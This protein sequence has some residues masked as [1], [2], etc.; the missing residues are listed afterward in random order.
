MEINKSGKPPDKAGKPEEPQLAGPM[1]AS[2]A[3]YRGLFENCVD[4][5]F[6]TY[7]A[8]GSVLASN[9]AACKLTG[10]SEQELLSMQ[11]EQLI[12]MTE[13]RLAAALTSAQSGEGRSDLT[14]IRKNGERFEARISSKLFTDE[15]GRE[16]A[17][18]IVQDMTERKAE[19]TALRQ[20]AARFRLL[21]ENAPLGIIQVDP[22]GT[23]TTAN[24][25]F[26]EIS[27]Y[28]PEEAVG[29][30]PR[31]A[32]LPEAGDRFEKFI[33]DF[34]AGKVDVF[35][36][37]ERL[38][39]KDGTTIW[40][41]QHAKLVRDELGRPHSGVVIF[42]DITRRKQAESSL[43]QSEEKFRATFEHMPIGISQCT[44]DGRFMDA[45]PK[46]LE[47]LG[48]T[49]DELRRLTINDVTHPAD[50]EETRV[51][52]R[53]MATG[54]ATP[55]SMETRYVRKDRSI[56]WVHVTAALTSLSGETNYLVTT[57]E[58]ISAR[59][60][61]E[62]EQKQSEA[63]LRQSEEKFR[64]TF[65]HVPLGI[66]ECTL[67][68]RFMDA[69]PKLLE[70]LGYTKDELRQLTINDV[71]HPADADQT[72]AHL[73]NLAAG[74]ENLYVMEKRYIR[75]DRSIVWV[76][77][78]AALT[79][80]AGKPKY[81]VTTIEDISA[82]KKT[83]ADLKQVME[84]SYYQAN[85]DM[86]T[87]L[88]NRSAFNDRLQEALAY[89]NRDEHMVAL[90]LI[91]LD[92]FKSINDTLGH[93][94]GDLLL[95]EVAKRIKSQIRATDLAARLGGDEFVVIQTHL[96]D[97]AAA[98]V[99]AGKL[100]EDIGRTY[101]LEGHEVQS[102]TS[103]GVAIY[104]NDSD[105]QRELIKQ[106]DLA[107]YEA[108]HRGRFNYQF[109]REELGRVIRKAQ[110][111]E[112]EL[113]RA[114]RD[115][116]FCLHYQPQFDLKGG[117]ITG[118]E[119]LLRWRH[120]TRGVLAAG[121]FIGDLERMKLMHPIGE[122]VLQTACR[123]YKEWS[124]AG[125]TVPLSV[126]LSPTQ[127]RDPRFLQTLNTI[128]DETG[129]PASLLQLETHESVLW[130]LKFT[131]TL[132]E[133]IGNTGLHFALD[134]FGTDLTALSA[135]NRFPLDAVKPSRGLMKE[136]NTQKWEATVLAAI[137][138]VAHN[139]K[140][141][142]CADGVETTDQLAAVKAQGC[143]SA[144]GYLL[145]EPLDA[146]EM[147]RIVKKEVLASGHAKAGLAAT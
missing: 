83:D 30:D 87:G 31:K 98:G 19:E 133:Q 101:Y 116:E 33:E 143:D 18:S 131:K 124:E 135:L 50:A 103:I 49:K 13:P 108:K 86:L 132:L 141:T 99:L 20:S 104:P 89:A 96:S 8:T 84:N 46:L 107:L 71:T 27:G 144:Q 17:C 113:L 63:S 58:D 11:R 39:R 100:V 147:T 62:A 146:Q 34:L 92:G 60:E 9:P 40:T 112:Q 37:E 90:H 74:D 75:K 65:E 7:P 25:K 10:Y 105:D 52:L 111:L 51:E 78:T 66:S 136:L 82:R 54:A 93:H 21:F 129:L 110:Q 45:N 77:V 4:A 61:T 80:I 64:A 16:L 125:L 122:W 12:D 95:K 145:S 59:K 67:D 88:A 127:L 42:E 115:N 126:N 102:G 73:R 5:I 56:V 55:Y 79:S 23:L 1:Q 114:M 43:R 140:M 118:V 119:A 68:G 94:I 14:F 81:L 121:D 72:Q 130:D 26:A 48:Y 3:N 138:D 128:L 85:H 41:R 137:I 123:Q 106:A 15:K 28:S 120:P 117:R 142:V 36:L 109:Y 47:I 57:I 134:D 2:E 53:K 35:D 91:D 32:T 139:L 38:L 24:P 6:L 70:I 97:P 69:N 22:R 44:L 29:L 76:N